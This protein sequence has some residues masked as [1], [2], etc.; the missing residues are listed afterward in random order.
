M[1][2]APWLGIL[3]TI[4]ICV[5]AGPAV[6]LTTRITRSECPAPT[7]SEPPKSQATP[8][9]VPH[10]ILEPGVHWDH[11]LEDDAHLVPSLTG[12]LFYSENGTNGKEPSSV[13]V[14]V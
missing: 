14:Q 4:V 12:Q 1:S 13:S 11:D 3:T 9:A 2:I 7:A 10:T 5:A 6:T 8:A